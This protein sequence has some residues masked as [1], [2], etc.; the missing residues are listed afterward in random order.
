M[1]KAEFIKKWRETNAENGIEVSLSQLEQL[2]ESLSCTISAALCESEEVSLPGVGKLKPVQVSGRNR[3]N[4]KTGEQIF[5]PAHLK[6]VFRPSKAFS[7][8]LN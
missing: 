5:V 4:P 1:K 6:V 7:E 3:L 8:R 2:L